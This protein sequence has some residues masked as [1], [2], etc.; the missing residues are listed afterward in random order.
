MKAFAK[1][2]RKHW[3][4][5]VNFYDAEMTSGQLEG[6]RLSQLPKDKD[7]VQWLGRIVGRRMPAALARIRNLTIATLWF[8]LF[9]IRSPLTSLPF[10]GKFVAF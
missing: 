1:T 6:Y 2:L 9:D 8:S 7:N 4:E 5:I 10:F 3:Q